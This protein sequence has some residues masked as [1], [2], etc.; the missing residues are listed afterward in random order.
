MIV[1]IN[2][3]TLATRDLD[4]S[5][6]FY[7]DLLG[8]PWL[9]KWRN[10]VYLL[11]GDLWLCLSLDVQTK[12]EPLPE[13]THIA[14][15]VAREG[16]DQICRHLITNDIKI[17]KENASEGESLYILDPDHNK[18]ELHVSDWQSRINSIRKKPYADLQINEA[19]LEELNK[20]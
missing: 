20:R 13:Y 14:L 16:F 5:F 12:S 6:Q 7:H 15:T 8:I 17:W 18:L 3:V 19:F 9:A 11:A 4:E 2:H 10:G 1:G